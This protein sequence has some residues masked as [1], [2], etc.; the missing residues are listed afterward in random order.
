MNPKQPKTLF[1]LTGNCV[2]DRTYSFLSVFNCNHVSILH[3]FRDMT[4]DL[5]KI[6]YFLWSRGNFVTR[7]Y[8]RCNLN[9][10]VIM[11]WKNVDYRLHV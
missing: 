7:F 5:P 1:K 4:S 10:G 3:R 9:D 2:F 6:V 11:S 8:V